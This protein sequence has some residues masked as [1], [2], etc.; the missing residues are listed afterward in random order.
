MDTRA[1][2]NRVAARFA[3]AGLCIWFGDL[4][5]VGNH[6]FGVSFG[7]QYLFTSSSTMSGVPAAQ[8]M[9]DDVLMSKCERGCAA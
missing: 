1:S 7:L 5:S 3:E 9:G 8:A 4:W 6:A 2:W